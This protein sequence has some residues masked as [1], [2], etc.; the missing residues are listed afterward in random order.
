MMMSQFL[1]SLNNSINRFNRFNSLN[2]ITQYQHRVNTNHQF[3]NNIFKGFNKMPI[4]V[5][6]INQFNN[7]HLKDSLF[8]RLIKI[9]LMHLM[10]IHNQFPRLNN[11]YPNKSINKY[12]NK[13]LNCQ[14]IY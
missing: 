13:P 1:S 14:S 9:F 6:I 4:K 11:S 2:N 10:M 12:L 5:N 3:S 7:S 8:N